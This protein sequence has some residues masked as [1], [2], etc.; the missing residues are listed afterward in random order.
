MTHQHRL[1]QTPGLKNI[2]SGVCFSPT[3]K[4]LQKRIF[5]IQPLDQT[6]HSN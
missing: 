3:V 2:N 5:K 6:I 1:A 4:H